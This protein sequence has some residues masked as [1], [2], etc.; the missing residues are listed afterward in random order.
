MAGHN[1]LDFKKY[2]SNQSIIVSVFE[3][4]RAG[5]IKVRLNTSDD[6][7]THVWQA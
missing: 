7:L 3:P 1:G 2:P 6:A 5:F 4:L